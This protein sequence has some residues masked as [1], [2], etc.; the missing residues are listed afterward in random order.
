M[1]KSFIALLLLLGHFGGTLWFAFSD[2]P[3]AA[4]VFFVAWAMLIG[5]TALIHGFFS[6]LFAPLFR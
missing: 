4:L 2:G 6:R 5:L 3:A 1:L